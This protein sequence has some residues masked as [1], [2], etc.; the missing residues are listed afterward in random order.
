M[1][2]MRGEELNWA[3]MPLSGV[4]QTTDGAVVLVGAFKQHPLRDICA[5]LEIDDLSAQYPTLAVQRRHRDALQAIFRETFARQSTAHWLAR[6]ESQDLLCAPVKSLEQALADPQTH[7]NGMIAEA[8]YGANGP[9][10]LVG[11]PVHLSAAPFSVR[12]S[13][14]SLGE[15]ST[16]ILRELDYDQ[17][18]IDALKDQGVLG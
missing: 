2:L 8:E 16:A 9:I 15:H 3:A 14:P 7:H 10:K 6:L 18:R 12:Q 4:F 11:S 5:A 13:P 17:S 1:A